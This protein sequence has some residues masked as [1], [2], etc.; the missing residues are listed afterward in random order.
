MILD[1]RDEFRVV[2]GSVLA[3][4]VVFSGDGAGNWVVGCPAAWKLAVEF[5]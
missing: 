1:P 3:L 4:V 5:Y 2:S